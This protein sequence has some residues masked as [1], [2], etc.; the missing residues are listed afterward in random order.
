[1]QVGAEML[2]RESESTFRLNNVGAV[3]LRDSFQEPV[4]RSWPAPTNSRLWSDPPRH[5]HQRF[6]PLSEGV[7]DTILPQLRCF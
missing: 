6:P 1:M 2:T 7:D 5:A 3:W 4:S